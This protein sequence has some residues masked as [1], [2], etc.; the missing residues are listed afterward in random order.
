MP[1][2]APVA[3][4][5]NDPDLLALAADHWWVEAYL[6]GSGWTDLDPSFP[7]AGPGD[8]FVAST[9]TDGTD[10]IAS[11]PVDQQHTISVRL[12]VEQYSTF[13]ISGAN[14]V[15]SYPLEVTFPTAQVAG[16]RLTFA[17]FVASEG[18]GGVFSNVI[19]TYTPY[20]LIEENNIA[21]E[22]DPFQDFISN[23]PLSSEFT[24]AE[25]V[26]YE[27]TD[28]DGNS[29][30]FTRTV[31][32]LIG[33]DARLSGGALSLT[34]DLNS[35]PFALLD[36]LYVNWVL[37]NKVTDWAHTRWT[38]GLLPRMVEIAQHGQEMLVIAASGGPNDELTPEQ[39]AAFSAARTQVVFSSERLLTDIGLDFAWQADRTLSAIETGLQTK[40]YYD[41]P[42]VFTVAS[43]G[44]PT[45]AVTSTVDLRRTT[46]RA[47]VYPD[48]AETAEFT[49]QWVKG[50]A[51][52]NLEGQVLEAVEGGLALTTWRIFDEMAVQGIPPVLLS[53]DD[54]DQLDIYP[55]SSLT[56]A[57]VATALAAGQSVLIPSEPVN[58]DGE[59]VFAWWEIDPET[60]ETVSVGEDGLHTAALILPD[61]RADCRSR[62]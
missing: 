52:S 23:F 36:D 44:D 13:P 62:D 55:F 54:L 35:R 32:D 53:P 61:R 39:I 20:F 15:E 33:A 29:E 46:A 57:Y 38:L 51:E 12:K 9:A 27:I 45:V 14:L 6:P 31:K 17:H 10:R 47:I 49:A 48:Q 24:T 25:W 11:L 8:V 19:H 42:R 16:K 5:L 22:G 21:Y 40:L 56:Q 2:G 37:P 4:P 34:A 30:S 58:I 3:D 43:V 41:S 26:E 18:Q 7:S 60:G 59:E 1:A 50:L 28:P